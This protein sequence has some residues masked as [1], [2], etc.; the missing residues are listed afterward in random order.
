MTV[1]GSSW[2]PPP[3]AQGADR[4]DIRRHNL[5][6]VL[7]L[8]AAGGPRS[9][10]GLATSTG[11][12]KA[13][14]SSLVGELMSRRLVRERG[15]EGGQRLGR[16]ATLVELDGSHVVTLGVELN[17]GHV[18]VLGADLRGRSVYEHRQDL[19]GDTRRVDEV[20][21]QLVVQVNQAVDDLVA[22]QCIVAGASVAI[23]GI[24]DG[25]RGVV[26]FAPNLAWRGV[27]LR[28]LLAGRLRLPVEL[29]LFNEA[30]LGAVAEHRAGGHGAADDLVY[31]LAADGVG[32][33]VIVGGALVLGVGGAAG[34]LG[35]TTVQARGRRCTCG[36]RG[37]WETLIAARGLLHETMPD[38][39][40]GLLSGGR[41]SAD[42]VVAAVTAA[43]H[44]K[45]GAVLE[46]L[47]SYGRW[48]GIGLANVID[49]FNPGVVVLGG[50]LPD[51]APWVLPAAQEAVIRH[52]LADSARACRIELTRLGFSPSAK[53]GAIV[54]AERIFADPTV[55]AAAGG[56][57]P[58]DTPS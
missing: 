49:T 30:N 36:S 14:V 7:R 5:S 53:G 10:A 31:I 47:R 32:A 20:V 41:L 8:L 42:D 40:D 35:H 24:V 52:S 3:G 6:V 34:E 11:L 45:D 16:P 54:A 37:C 38:R 4:L 39:A 15:P 56:R 48:L 50:F 58:V 22:R 55:V 17:V 23:P 29:A 13:T 19:H 18:R 26:T 25:E 2:P 46:G 21:D 27:P 51:I 1:N 9:R 57:V 43:A 28:Q 33:G 12:T 44:A